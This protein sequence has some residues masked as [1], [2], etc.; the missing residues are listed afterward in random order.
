MPVTVIRDNYAFIMQLK[1]VN[2]IK[3]GKILRYYVKKSC[4]FT[5]K[6]L[7]VVLMFAVLFTSMVSLFAVNKVSATTGGTT[8]GETIYLNTSQNSNWENIGSLNSVYALFCNDSGTVLGSPS[9][10]TAVSGE[11]H[12]LS[13]QAPDG[14]TKVQVC[15]ASNSTVFPNTLVQD[16]CRRVYFENN[17][18]WSTPYLYCWSGGS[19]NSAWPGKAM[20]QVGNTNTYYYDVPTNL[21]GIIFNDGSGK[22]GVGVNKTSDLTLQSI[23]NSVYSWNSS[24][25]T[26]TSWNNTPYITKSAIVDFSGRTTGANE[27]YI[28][29]LDT[30]VLSKYQ[31]PSYNNVDMETVYLYNTDWANSDV[32]VKYDLSDPYN[33]VLKMTPDASKLGYFSASV[34]KNAT[35]MFKPNQN[36][37]YGASTQTVVPSGLTEPCYKMTSSTN[38]WSELSDVESGYYDYFASNDFSS[39]VFGVEA[40]YFDYL[41]DRELDTNYGWL[42]PLQAGTGFNGSSD[43]WYP[44]YEFNKAINTVSSANSGNWKYP[45]YFGN[46]CNTPGS[47]DTSAH[48]G[49]YTNA[50]NGLT[51]FNY[52]VNNSNGLKDYNYS[53]RGLA[54]DQLS[55]N[56]YIQAA[57]GLNMPYFDDQW[58]NDK[59]MAK[60]IKSYFPFRETT[61]G[62]VSTFSFDS[63]DAKDNVYFNWEGTTPQSVGYGSGTQYGVKDGIAMFMNGG[64]SGYGIFPF[65]NTAKTKGN[66]SGSDNLDYGFGIKLDMDFRVP[67]NGLLPNGTAATFDYSGD[68]DLWIY[69]TDEDGNSQLVLDLGGNHKQ[70]EGSIDFSTMTATSKKTASFPSG[71]L[72]SDKI[73]ITDSYNWGQMYVWAWDNSNAGDWY[74]C[75]TDSSGRY[76]VSSAD[77]GNKGVALSTKTKFLVARDESYTD[78]TS[79]AILADHYGKNTYT[80]NITYTDSGSTDIQYVDSFQQPFGFESNGSGGYKTLDPAKTYHMTVFYMERGLIESNFK[81]SFTMTPAQND[82]KV[83]K[84]VNAANVNPALVDDVKNNEQFTFTP[85][86]EGADVTN[87][88]YTLIDKDTTTSLICNT[89][90]QLK[91]GETADFNNQFKTGSNMNIVETKSSGIQYNTDWTLINNTTGGVVSQET[92]STSATFNLVDPDNAN[93]FAKLQLNYVNTPKVANVV[94]EKEVR[95]EDGEAIAANVE[96]SFAFDVKVD[97][98]GGT[99]YK[100]YPLQYKIEYKDGS[101]AVYNATSEGLITFRTDEKVTLLNLPVG[102]TY[103]VSEHASAGYLPHKW[104]LNGGNEQDFT[105]VVNGQVVDTGSTIKFINRRNPTKTEIN[106]VKTLDS[107][108]FTGDKFSFTLSG[109]SSMDYETESGTKQ[110]HDLNG[111]LLTI[112]DVVNGKFTFRNDGSEILKYNETGVYRYKITEEAITDT[113]YKTSQIVYLVQITVTGSGSELIVSNPEYY[114]TNP[115]ITITSD[116]DYAQF[117]NDSYK[118]ATAEF[119]NE[120]QK[121]SVTIIKKNQNDEI[122][123]GTKFA[124]YK[125]SEDGGEIPTTPFMEKV[126]DADGKALFSDLTIFEDGYTDQSAGDPKYQWYCVAEIEPTTGYAI[127]STKKYFTL[128]VN[129]EEI[130]HYDISYTYI[131][132]KIITPDA[133]GSGTNNF[134]IVGLC[135]LGLG[136]SSACAYFMYVRKQ[137]K[138]RYSNTKTK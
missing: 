40:T 66:R 80:N 83:H 15:V 45:L 69:I 32:Y 53:V 7:P 49:P 42:N 110:T 46:F 100:A 94:L 131:N 135:I 98:A 61:S 63:T 127:N 116:A 59:G 25:P 114:H 90:F 128:P 8:S 52:E 117:F 97:I 34:P 50:I 84:Q 107:Q 121:G 91:D 85:K 71:A 17:A 79:D 35:L 62:D 3:G 20:T 109:L 37:D 68:D 102:A 74:K 55:S 126:S 75:K 93:D 2:F 108:D 36:N 134:L 5:S 13:V 103:Q 88:P 24:N 86:E 48:S 58:L 4:I 9:K 81:V 56:G 105:G 6:I 113:D 119:N 16:G 124:L 18:N 64:T 77:T 28:S 132:G 76:Y 39:G 57:D 44:F 47:Y 10:F 43:N 115:D 70:A 129:E 41:S 89:D 65:N 54:Y 73:Y 30:G 136:V 96:D 137:S 33:T 133:S 19:N 125:V 122:L 78:Q 112:N 111:Q 14:A 87:T 23:D 123:N 120:T 130:P 31:Y 118:V 95:E 72:D 51:N 101:T 12:L 27:I 104:T 92:N 22:Y 99:N 67:E 11:T 26:S 21:T 106:G 1:T 82:L 38:V 138:R 29:S 60:I